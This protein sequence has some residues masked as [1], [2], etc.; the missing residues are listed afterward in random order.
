[1]KGNEMSLEEELRSE[2]ESWR[3]RVRV[4][5]EQT[6]RSE[7]ELAE[8]KREIRLFSEEANER[9]GREGWCREYDDWIQRSLEDLPRMRDYWMR[10]STTVNLTN[11]TFVFPMDSVEVE[12]HPENGTFE[13]SLKKAIIAALEATSIDEGS[14]IGATEYEGGEFRWDR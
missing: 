7:N 3:N 13:E 11:A 5:N 12:D 8:F 9:A 2:I 1:M 14:L 10:R 6:V 4:A